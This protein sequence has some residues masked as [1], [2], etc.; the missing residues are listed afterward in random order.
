MSKKIQIGSPALEWKT[1]VKPA[2]TV[3]S[4]GVAIEENKT[5]NIENSK[6]LKEK[7]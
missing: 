5:I 6:F 4:C 3:N 2:M 7:S 1:H